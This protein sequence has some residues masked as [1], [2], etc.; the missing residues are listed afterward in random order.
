MLKRKTRKISL[1]VVMVTLLTVFQFPVNGQEFFIDINGHE[2]EEDIN[3]LREEGYVE[4]VGNSQYKPDEV[5]TNAQAIQLAVNV[6]DLNLDTFRF[7]KEPMATDY[8]LEA[9]NDAWYAEAFIIAGANTMKIDRTIMPDNPITGQNFIQLFM[10]EDAPGNEG[11]ISLRF[12][13]TRAEAANSIVESLDYLKAQGH[14]PEE[15]KPFAS[16]LDTEVGVDTIDFIFDIHNQ[17]EE[18]QVITFSSS[19]TFDFDVYNSDGEQVYNW[20]SVRSFIMM[21][22]EVPIEKD[23]YVRYE[24]PW[25]Y[26]DATGEKLPAGTYKVVFTSQFA[27]EEESMEVSSEVIIDIP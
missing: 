11:M 20:A 26:K 19:Q 22:N 17:T 21:I 7:I 2:Y 16:S 4:G 5:L 24:V 13:L 1:A 10:L 9:N 12:D 27:L 6:F 14:I 8:F 23:S 18:D 25:D 3:R 15:E